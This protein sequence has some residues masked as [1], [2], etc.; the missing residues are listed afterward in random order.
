MAVKTTD[1]D[2]ELQGISQ[3]SFKSDPRGLS[4]LKLA[5][6]KAILD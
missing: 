4:F 5:S 3:L 1:H 6:I 2:L